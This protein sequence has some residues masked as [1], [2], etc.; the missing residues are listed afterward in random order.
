MFLNS[1]KYKFWV[2]IHELTDGEVNELGETEKEYKKASEFFALIETR[3]G[4]LLAGRPADTVLSKTTHKITYPY[5]N[6]T[7]LEPEKHI[8]KYENK[9][10]NIEYADGF[11]KEEMEVFCS[12]TN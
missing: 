3:A 5:F 7:E 11:S 1:G 8:I 12:C 4:S 6:F 9:V 2:E 10:F